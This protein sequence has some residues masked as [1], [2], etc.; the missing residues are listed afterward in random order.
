MEAARSDE[1]IRAGQLEIRPDDALVL[2]DGRPL[3]LSVREYGVLLALA[4]RAPRIAGPKGR[5]PPER[6]RVPSP[7][8]VHLGAADGR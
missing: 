7:R 1:V 8:S 5:G 6:Y 4:S 2:A 3:N